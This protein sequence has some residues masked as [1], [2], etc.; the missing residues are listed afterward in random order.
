MNMKTSQYVQFGCGFSAPDGWLNFDASPTLRFE[1]L[2]VLGKFYT[3][4][5]RRFPA[6]VVYGDVI[7]GLPVADGSCQGIYCSHVL[8]HLALDEFDVT[9]GNVF[10]Y[11]QPGGTFRMVLPDLEQLARDYL[12][13]QEENAA[14]R[15]MGD[16]YLGVKTRPRGLSGLVR[17]WLGNS[18]HLWMWDER[19]LGAKLRARGFKEVRRA[20]FGDA[21]DKKFNE[22]E[23][24]GRFA[25][26]LGMQCRK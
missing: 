2:P 20:A 3:R 12:A 8:E 1:R 4:N 21:E 26:C 6:N 11:L 22:V 15:F 13:S 19:S 7:K 16:S 25:N 10:R 14:A 18:A 17:T 24:A 9:L 5:A 23:D